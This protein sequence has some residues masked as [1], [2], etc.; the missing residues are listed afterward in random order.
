MAAWWRVI[1]NIVAQIERQ[2]DSAEFMDGMFFGLTTSLN[3]RPFLSI[4]G[5][6]HHA[7]RALGQRAQLLGKD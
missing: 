1:N 7:D 5:L 6:R 3:V 2:T 4:L